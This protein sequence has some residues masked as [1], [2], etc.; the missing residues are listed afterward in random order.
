MCEE[1]QFILHVYRTLITANLRFEH[2][3]L[4]RTERVNPDLNL[5]NLTVNK[6]LVLKYTMFNSNSIIMK[7]KNKKV[8]S[9]VLTLLLIFILLGVI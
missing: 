8:A 9:W 2:L 5:F 7:K 6:Q 1:I 4:M 3:V